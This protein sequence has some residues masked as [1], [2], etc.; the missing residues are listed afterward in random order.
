MSTSGRYSPEFR[1]SAAWLGE[2]QEKERSSESVSIQSSSEKWGCVPE[3][4]RRRVCR[5][6][7]DQG[8]HPARLERDF[9][10]QGQAV[11]VNPGNLR[12]PAGLSWPLLDDMT[13]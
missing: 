7:R 1:E 3:I 11:R 13:C 8:K 10:F 2:E 4:L 9:Y 5:L 6:Q 12:E